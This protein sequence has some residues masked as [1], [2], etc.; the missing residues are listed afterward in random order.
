MR[1]GKADDQ[2][3][4]DDQGLDKSETDDHCRL[5]LARRFR[6]SGD[7]LQSRRR[8][9]SLGHCAREDRYRNSK[10]YRDD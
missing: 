9:L 2:K 10:P 7:T 1:G 6:L 3:R 8:G 5:N 4:V